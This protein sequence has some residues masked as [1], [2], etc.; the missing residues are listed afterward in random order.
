VV[1]SGIDGDS[2]SLR[3]AVSLRNIRMPDGIGSVGGRWMPTTGLAEK[4]ALQMAALLQAFGLK[5]SSSSRESHLWAPSA[6]GRP[7]VRGY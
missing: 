5:P 6:A 2:G 4:G 1:T 3:S 7:Q